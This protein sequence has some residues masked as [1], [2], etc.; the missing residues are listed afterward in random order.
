[1]RK[2]LP[3]I[4]LLCALLLL[5]CRAQLP[6]EQ[7]SLRGIDSITVQ[8]YL[9]EEAK[10]LSLD[11][12]RLRTI[13]ELELRLGGISVVGN[14]SV[15]L[16]ADTRI[17]PLKPKYAEA[18]NDF[19]YC[20]RLYIAQWAYVIRD[21]PFRQFVCTWDRTSFGYATSSSGE[22]IENGWKKMAQ[23]FVND[24]LKVNPK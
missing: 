8:V 15:V 19:A 18:G 12:S 17:L 2:I 11:E 4:V 6:N 21:S 14:S 16:M 3:S 20:T 10:L 22:I 7:N 1:M 24:Y 5:N 23:D 9:A 13:I